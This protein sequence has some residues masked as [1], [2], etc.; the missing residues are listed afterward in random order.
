MIRITHGSNPDI[1]SS[2]MHMCGFCSYMNMGLCLNYP[3][4]SLSLSL[5]VSDA[6][7]VPL[8]VPDDVNLS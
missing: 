1:I 5:H 7:G 2:H 3:F 8:S 6:A 4:L